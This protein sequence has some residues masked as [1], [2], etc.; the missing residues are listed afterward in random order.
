MRRLKNRRGATMILVGVS[1]LALVG[2]MTLALEMG[3]MY[4]FRAQVHVSS[5]AAAL[6]GA[7][8]L[9]REQYVG[10]ADTAVA[11]GRLNLV[12]R[13]VPS[14][15]TA[16]I[17]PGVWNFTTNTF[18]PAAGGWA[19]STNN[20]VRATSRYTAT[21]RFG[22]LFGL[23]TRLR[24][25]T[26]V[27]AVGSVSGTSC[28]RPIA[29]PYQRLLDAR[30]G[31]G[32]KNAV[33]YSLTA[34]DVQW[35]G[36]NH[37]LI[38]LKSGDAT[39][40]V[41]SGN[42]Y[43]IRM[44]PIV[45]ADGTSGNPWQGANDFSDALGATC[46]AL[47]TKV[48]SAG[49]RFTIGVGD[50][51]LAEN[52]NMVTKAGDGVAALCQSNGGISPPNGGGN[53]S[54]TCNVPTRMVISMWAEHGNAPGTSGCGGKCF[55]VK[56]VGVFY[57]TEYIKGEGVRGYFSDLASQGKFSSIPSLIKKIALVQ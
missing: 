2:F 26:S 3:R 48:A 14:I 17:E 55:K 28:V 39:S 18:T 40:N 27:A 49:G 8:R 45:Y 24:T 23:T 30:Y 41:I 36:D 11:Y 56:Y 21:Y 29:V 51:M 7:E 5:D 46:D 1:L 20:A 15:T 47:A 6:A 52:G 4:L 25:A 22:R 16:D 9:L 57:L 13:V 34:D 54:F 38:L 50:W 12:E 43:G 10:A 31:D 33:T 44:P 19:A 35:F 37:P 32:V 42:F 53:K